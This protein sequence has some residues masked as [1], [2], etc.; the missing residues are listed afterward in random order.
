MLRK[1]RG[2]RRSLQ[3]AGLAGAALSLAACSASAEERPAT[4]TAQSFQAAVQRGD[5]AAACALLSSGA[6]SKL[7]SAS[8]SSCNKA[9]LGLGLDGGS[10]AS[11]AVWGSTAQ[12]RT[13]GGVLFL[14]ELA[15]GWR[16]RAAGCKPV[17]DKPYD[18]DVEA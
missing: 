17:P 3:L 8:G 12:A 14:D 2:R 10:V 13:G 4:A 15:S 6:A 5:G 16:V 1:V 7:E 9:I 11:V 18:C